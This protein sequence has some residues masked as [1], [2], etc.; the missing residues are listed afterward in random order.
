MT[1]F[2]V[3]WE[4]DRSSLPATPKEKIGIIM[5]LCNKVKEDVKSGLLADWGSFSNNSGYFIF[6]GTDE[7]VCLYLIKYTTFLKFSKPTIIISI[8]QAIESYGKLAQ[9]ILKA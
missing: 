4:V 7:D 2:F 8:D 6:N 3:L 1:K 5:S 9:L